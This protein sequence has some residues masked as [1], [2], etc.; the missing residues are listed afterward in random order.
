MT[1]E[2]LTAIL[3][4]TRDQQGLYRSDESYLDWSSRTGDGRV[5][6]VGDAHGNAVQLD[7]SRAELEH[8]VHRLAATLLND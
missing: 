6:E 2:Q 1:R 4:A 8:L 7:L 3:T 5:F